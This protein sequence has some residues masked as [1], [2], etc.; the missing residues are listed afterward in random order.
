M[1]VSS[2]ERHRDRELMRRDA[3]W[4]Q[5]Q[6]TARRREDRG[7]AQGVCGENV[8]ELLHHPGPSGAV[9]RTPY[10]TEVD[11][12]EAHA[13]T[14]RRR[15]LHP[16]LVLATRRELDMVILIEPIVNRMGADA[17]LEA[18]RMA[19]ALNRN[20][21]PDA[22]SCQDIREREMVLGRAAARRNKRASRRLKVR[23]RFPPGVCEDRLIDE[24]QGERRWSL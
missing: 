7:R 17:A 13:C 5:R 9:R 8:W 4:R 21:L 14:P 10:V 11:T 16:L 6:R 22:E 1:R 15:P 18:Q 24:I 3:H 20:V 2:W 23:R 12:A 19:R